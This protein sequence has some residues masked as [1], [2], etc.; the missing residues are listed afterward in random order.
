MGEE[1]P[2]TD[3]RFDENSGGRIG[4]RS[5]GKLLTALSVKGRNTEE[6]RMLKEKALPSAWGRKQAVNVK[7]SEP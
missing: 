1:S 3:S 5:K 4:G 2:V 6:S 7:K